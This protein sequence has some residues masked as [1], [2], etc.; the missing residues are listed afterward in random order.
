MNTTTKRITLV[1]ILLS[2]AFLAST[3]GIIVGATRVESTDPSLVYATWA[4]TFMTLAL[5]IGVPWTIVEAGTSSEESQRRFLHQEKDRFYAQLDATYVGIQKMT[6]ER[7]HLANPAKERNVDEH[8]QHDAFAFIVWNFV[9]SI[10]DYSCPDKPGEE[11][12]GSPSLWE[13]WQCIQH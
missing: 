9:E 10:Y 4:L 1:R 11:S 5:A 6:I 2:A 12:G 7:P 13:T 3:A 8:V